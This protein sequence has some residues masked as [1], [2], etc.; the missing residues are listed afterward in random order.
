MLAIRLDSNVE[1]RLE[2]L[3]KKT[4]RTKSFFA[5]QAIMEHLE[6]M[7]DYYLAV[8]TLQKHGRIFSREET[9]SELGL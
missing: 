6:D 9:K 2:A 1:E 4:G 8:D 7:E 3:A 5:R